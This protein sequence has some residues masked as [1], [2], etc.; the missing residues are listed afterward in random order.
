MNRRTLFVVLLTLVIVPVPSFGQKTEKP[1]R[2]AAVYGGSPS[3]S[4]P[5]RDAFVA[6]LRERGYE[7]GRNLVFDIRYADAKP[8]RYP[9]LV[10]EILSLKPDVV[11]AA[12]TPVALE[13]KRKTSTIPIVLTTSGNP[14]GDGLVQ[15]LSRPGGNITG[16]SSQVVELGAKH[17]EVLAELL[18]GMRSVALLLDMSETPEQIEAYEKFISSAATARG[19]ALHVHR[20]TT[21]EGIRQA[22]KAMEAQRPDAL[23]LTPSARLN[24]QRREIVQRAGAIRLASISSIE[25]YAEEGGLVSYGPSWVELNRHAAYF[26]D[27][28]LKGAKPAD[29]PLQQPTKFS[30][31]VNART[32]KGLGVRIPQSILARADRIID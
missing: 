13:M 3:T 4:G 15:S 26:V 24:S 32:A 30:L 23:I 11:I 22:F 7:V 2:V 19:V 18:P 6:G 29:L 10:D 1:W 27:R 20:V 14:V 12:N 25:D 17:M 21:S 5:Y 8:E 28:I 16:N 9:V 31:I